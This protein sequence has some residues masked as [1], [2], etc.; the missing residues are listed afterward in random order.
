MTTRKFHTCVYV[1]LLVVI[2]ILALALIGKQEKKIIIPPT[3]TEGWASQVTQQ[4][5]LVIKDKQ[6][7][8][9]C[10]RE[11]SAE[12]YAEEKDASVFDV[13]INNGTDVVLELRRDGEKLTL[14]IASW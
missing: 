13:G 6:I 9:I 5:Y 8:A 2:V 4:A 10:S 12:K 1:T 7:I 3:L 11:E 14:N